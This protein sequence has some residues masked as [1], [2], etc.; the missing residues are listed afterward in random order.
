MLAGRCDE[1]VAIPF[2]AFGAALEWF[3]R[4]TPGD[5]VVDRLGSFPGIWNGSSRT[6][7]TSSQ[8]CRQR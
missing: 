4:H 1:D 7:A 6:W 8:A 3:V 5:T 2:Q